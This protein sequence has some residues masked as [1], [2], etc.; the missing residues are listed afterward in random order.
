MWQLPKCL[1]SLF[2]GTL[3]LFEGPFS[4]WVSLREN[5]RIR[6]YFGLYFSAFGLNID[7]SNSEYGHLF[8]S[9]SLTLS[10][11]RSLSYRNQSTDFSYKLMDWF[12]YERDLRPETVNSMI[13]TYVFKNQ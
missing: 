10:W 8:H 7:Q 12:L 6:R 1:S 4:M 3:V 2:V 13:L 11:Q 9:V 5:V